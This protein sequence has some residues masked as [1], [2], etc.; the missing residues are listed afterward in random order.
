MFFSEQ[1][2]YITSANYFGKGREVSEYKTYDPAFS[3]GLADNPNK[4]YGNNARLCRFLPISEGD[5]AT[6]YCVKA[7]QT[8]TD[9]PRYGTGVLP[10]G[11]AGAIYTTRSVYLPKISNPALYCLRLRVSVLADRA[12]CPIGTPRFGDY[13]P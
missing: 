9:R 11:D 2:F 3:L 6:A 1:R 13:Q 4:Q 12:L 8:V 5:E 10:K 7:P